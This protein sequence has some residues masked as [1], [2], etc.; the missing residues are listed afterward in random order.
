MNFFSHYKKTTDFFFF[1]GNHVVYVIHIHKT[2][3]KY[4]NLSLR[5]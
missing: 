5:F 2:M 1:F 3:K 4:L